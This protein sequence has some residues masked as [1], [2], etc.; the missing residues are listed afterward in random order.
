METNLSR[1]LKFLTALVLVGFMIGCGG[2]TASDNTSPKGDGKAAPKSETENNSR[3]LMAN[4]P[5][6]QK[7]R[8]EAIAVNNAK[9][10]VQGLTI[11][12]DSDEGKLPVAD[13]WGDAIL[14]EMGALAV[15]LSPQHPET[16]KLKAAL[17]NGGALKEPQPNDDAI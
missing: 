15:F 3:L 10:L 4:K 17:P 11:Y 13:K 6:A 16:A 14:Q 5:K 1:P 12:S 8:D 9:Q 2:N 7:R